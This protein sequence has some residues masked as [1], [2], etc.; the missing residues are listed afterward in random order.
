MMVASVRAKHTGGDIAMKNNHLVRKLASPICGAILLLGAGG[1][2]AFASDEAGE[3]HGYFRAGV[4]S[5]STH[6]P[7]SCFGLGGNTMK[8]RLGNECDSYA[9][10]GYTKEIA[11]TSN[12]A[13]FVGTIWA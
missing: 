12:G 10:F 6:G 2:P 4:G 1:Q 7:Q 11:K 3:F 5:S 13:S 8:Y 9:E